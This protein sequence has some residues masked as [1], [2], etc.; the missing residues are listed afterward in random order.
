M[1]FREAE[2]RRI[3]RIRLPH[4][5]NPH[6]YLRLPLLADGMTGPWAELYDE[7]CQRDVLHIRPRSQ[8]IPAFGVYLTETDWEPYTG[9]V[10]EFEQHEEAFAR[11]YLE[12]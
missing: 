8:R 12:S 11:G 4:W 3:P 1:T 6:A 7:G 5:S 10:S 9:P 2:D